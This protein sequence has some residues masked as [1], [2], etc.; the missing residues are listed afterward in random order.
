MLKEFL[1]RGENKPRA[2]MVL[3]FHRSIMVEWTTLVPSNFRSI[4]HYA[5]SLCTTGPQF[6]VKPKLPERQIHAVAASCSSSPFVTMRIARVLGAALTLCVLIA[7]ATELD[8]EQVDTTIDSD[9]QKQH[10]QQVGLGEE[11]DGVVDGVV[12]LGSAEKASQGTL[13][14]G[15]TSID[16]DDSLFSPGALAAIDQ[17][18]ADSGNAGSRRRR[19]RRRR[20][21]SAFRALPWFAG[22]V[23]RRMQKGTRMPVPKPPSPPPPEKK[24]EPA[25]LSGAAHD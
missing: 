6:R 25:A 17:D 19:R 4:C 13:T 2:R 21:T 9:E 18:L 15:S 10:P 20:N 16:T 22:F 7:F 1:A 23:R 5:G 24:G 3:P 8:I 11:L 12:E 14:S